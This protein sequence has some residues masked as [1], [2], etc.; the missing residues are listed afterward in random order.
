MKYEE[1][2]LT[3]EY[4]RDV[5]VTGITNELNALNGFKERDDYLGKLRKAH[6]EFNNEDEYRDFLE[7]LIDIE[8]VVENKYNSE[9]VDICDNLELFIEEIFDEYLLP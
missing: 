8:M 7:F 2:Y 6:Y 5:V 4:I 1:K 9:D 3:N